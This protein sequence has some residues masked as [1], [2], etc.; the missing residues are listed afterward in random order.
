MRASFWLA[1]IRLPVSFS[2]LPNTGLLRL[3]LMGLSLGLA[4]LPDFSIAQ[5]KWSLESLSPSGLKV[6]GRVTTAEGVRGTSLAFQGDSLLK[7]EGS[8]KLASNRS[9]FTLTAWVNPYRLD[10]R[11]QMIAAKNVYSLGQ[12]QWGV[13]IDKDNRFRLYVHQGRWVTAQSTIQPQPGH[14]H[15]VGVVIRP[16]RAQ[17][18]INGQAAPSVGLTRGIPGTGAPLTFAGV[19]D[20]GRMRQHWVGALDEIRLFDRPLSDEQMKDAYQPVK[21]MHRIPR[22]PDPVKLWTGGAFPKTSEAEILQGVRFEVIKRYEPAVDGYRFLHGVALAWHGGRLYAS[23][24]HNKGSE[25]TRTEEGRYCFS[26]DGGQSWS[27]VRTIDAGHKEK[28]LAVS[29]GV[30]LSH[31]GKLWAFLGSFYG[32]RQR[33]HTRAYTLDEQS[34]RWKP[35]GTVIRNGFWPMTEPVRMKDGNWILPGF[36]VGAGNP[37]AVAISDG[38]DLKN[39]KMVEI[40]R[41]EDVRHMWG[42]STVLVDGSNLLNLARYGGKPLTLVATSPDYGQSWSSSLESNLPMAASKP[43]AGVLS[44]GQRFLV[45]S[46]TADG[47][48]RRSPLTIAVSQPGQNSFSKLFVIRDAIQGQGPGESDRSAALSYP[49][50]VEYQ[51]HLY[52]GYSNN[53]GRKGNDNSAEMAVIPMGQL[54]IPSSQGSGEGK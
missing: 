7:A 11:Q 9:G 44:N 48:N 33:V 5:Q 54:A 29:H 40:A 1:L 19:D 31:R 22:L 13:M 37:A 30:F 51:G 24:G 14:W 25:N 17:L 50:A 38:D 8:Q 42:E 32:F 28:D 34:G 39:W 26:D 49:Y 12:R 52:V 16:G 2:F 21:A 47:G 43:C 4:A 35:Q 53:G 36:I 20:N 23:F 27:P 6:Q 46:M 41:G 45:G 3:C 10:G 15:L 18:W